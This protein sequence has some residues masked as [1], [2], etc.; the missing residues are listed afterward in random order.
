MGTARLPLERMDH[1]PAAGVVTMTLRQEGRSVVVL[2]SDLLR[3]IDATLDEVT[4]A[5]GFVVASDSR[6][7]VAG[8][9]L[10]EIMGLSDGELDAYLRFGSSVFGRIARMPWTTVAAIH[11]AALGGGLELAMHCDHLIAMAPAGEKG[12]LVGLPEAGLKICPGWGGT[13]MLPARMDAGRAMELTASGTALDVR[14]A[15]EAGLI[16]ELEPDHESLLCRARA[17]AAEPKHCARK[18]PIS[19]TNPEHHSSARAGLERVRKSVG[20]TSSGA[21]VLACV[22]AGLSGGW[23]SA[24]A[25][26]RASLIRLRNSDEGRAAITAFFEK[27]AKK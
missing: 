22:E 19:I 26:E 3:A 23:E 24:L 2:D 16:E 7:F 20:G 13:N 4:D 9:N 1:G 27:S 8:A 6:V 15:R 21:A 10:Q 17:L 5:K 11:G 25:C 12:Y 14:E 18:E